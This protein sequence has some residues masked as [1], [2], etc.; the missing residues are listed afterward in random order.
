[1]H[2]TYYNMDHRIKE[3]DELLRLERVR[4]QQLQDLL[5]HVLKKNHQQQ[6]IK[7]PMKKKRLPSYFIN[8]QR[9][10]NIKKKRERTQRMDQQQKIHYHL[11]F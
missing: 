9:Q 2:V 4:T 6:L 7:P 3:Q 11:K 1:M 10:K 5:R 8:Q